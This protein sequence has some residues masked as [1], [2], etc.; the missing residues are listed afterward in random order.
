MAVSVLAVSILFADLELQ[1]R[2]LTPVTCLR[3]M[4]ALP[5]EKAAGTYHR[6]KKMV[7]LT[8]SEKEMLIIPATANVVVAST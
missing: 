6:S 2:G 1:T 7:P 8:L 4:G 3:F 5:G